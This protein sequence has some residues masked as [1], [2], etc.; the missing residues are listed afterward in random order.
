M[1]IKANPLMGGVSL[2]AEILQD[3]VVKEKTV[4]KMGRYKVTIP[5]PSLGMVFQLV[6]A[7]AKIDR[8][9]F[10]GFWGNQTMGALIPR[11]VV[12]KLGETVTLLCARGGINQTMFDAVRT[13]SPVITHAR[14]KEE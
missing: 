6:R 10:K 5:P 4:I 1:A 14:I 8:V 12:G 2:Q 13:T 7:R 11:K 9:V 3:I